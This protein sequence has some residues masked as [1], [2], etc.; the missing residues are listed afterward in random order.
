MMHVVDDFLEWKFP[1]L[2]TNMS[3]LPHALTWHLL[4]N[5]FGAS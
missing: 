5:S 3:G 1:S 4:V 2:D